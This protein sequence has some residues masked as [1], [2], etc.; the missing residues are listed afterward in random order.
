MLISFDLLIFLYY[1]K[2]D[3]FIKDLNYNKEDKKAQY[4][5]TKKVIKFGFQADSFLLFCVL[6]F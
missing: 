1:K 4:T 6:T 5:R 3:L 2:L